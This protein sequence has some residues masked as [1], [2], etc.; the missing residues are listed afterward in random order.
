MKFVSIFFF[1]LL[2]L[3]FSYAESHHPQEFLNSVR[4]KKD[5]GMQIVSHFCSNCHALKPLIP[6]GAP[7]IKVEAD[8]NPRIKQGLATLLAHTEEGLNAMPPRGG[9]F[10]CS[11]KQLQLAILALL[12]KSFTKQES[13]AGLV[14]QGKKDHN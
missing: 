12:P 7:R 1:N 11:D 3:T 8:W 13:I 9:C 14:P 5:E 2:F 10:E 4:D 6:L